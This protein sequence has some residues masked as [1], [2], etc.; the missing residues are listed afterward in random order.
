MPELPEVETVA[1]QLAPLVSGRR[2]RR[3][4]VFDP[5]LLSA[6]REDLQDRPVR[7]VSRRG[8]RVAME[9]GPSGLKVGSQWLAVHL[10]MSGRL[11]WTTVSSPS[12]RPHLRAVLELEGGAV[13]FVDPRRFGT[14][15]WLSDPEE[16]VLG[17]DPMR[18]DFTEDRLARLLEGSTQSLKAWLLRQDRLVGVGN[19]YASEILHRARLSPFATG[20]SLRPDA[21]SRLHAAIREVLQAAIEHCGTTF[22]DFQ[23]AHGTA[24]GFEPF[25]QVYGRG[26]EPC[27]RCGGS[28]RRRVQHQRSTYY[29][30]RCQPARG[31]GRAKGRAK[32]KGRNRPALK[33]R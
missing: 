2:A 27:R 17:L 15:A 8:K 6:A 26:E 5:K 16:D 21:V 3:L 11:L 10:R 9:L 32:E 4:V 19:I 25:L 28:I 23:G 13:E 33:V 20:G 31:Q 29:C 1:R 18:A 12:C 14:L 30:P 24:G 7:E 22:S